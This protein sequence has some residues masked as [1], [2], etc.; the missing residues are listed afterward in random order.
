MNDTIV[1]LSTALATQAVSI[2]RVR[3]SESIKIVNNI[4][5]GKDCE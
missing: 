4:F 3:G 5:K 1:G 2:I